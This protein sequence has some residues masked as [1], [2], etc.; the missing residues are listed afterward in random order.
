MMR[1]WIMLAGLALLLSPAAARADWLFTPQIGGTFGNGS[2]LTYGASIGWVGTGMFGWE[3]E[4]ASTPGFLDRDVNDNPQ[5]NPLI[6]NSDFDDIDDHANSF[7]FNA[8]VGGRSRSG[9]TTTF[10]P[11]FSGGLGWVKAKIESEELLFDEDSTKFGFNLGAGIM[12]YFR[13]VGFRG[14]VRY[15]QTLSESEFDNTLG[16]EIGDYDYWRATAGVTFRF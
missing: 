14:D 1:K 16:L 6:A 8:V 7:M 2:G 3:A 13:H 10:R 4:F 12:T 5:I 9:A 15:Y 11:Y